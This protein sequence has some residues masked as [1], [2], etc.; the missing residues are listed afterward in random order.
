[1]AREHDCSKL[2]PFGW[3]PKE[4]F[5]AKLSKGAIRTFGI[6]ACRANKARWAWPSQ[7]DIARHLGSDRG[8]VRKWMRELERAR[9]IRTWRYKRDNGG[10]GTNWVL[11]A[12]FPHGVDSP[13]SDRRHEGVSEELTARPQ[14]EVYPLLDGEESP[15]GHG[16]EVTHLTENLNRE[17]EHPPVTAHG[18]AQ[19]ASDAV[20]DH[21]HHSEEVAALA[22]RIARLIGNPIDLE[23]ANQIH[24][25]GG[26]NLDDDDLLREI[27]IF[28]PKPLVEVSE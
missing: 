16:V 10:F 6:L 20:H 28:R 5:E 4:L 2:P 1:M 11:V 21:V 15:H 23:L 18:V 7:H 13:P 26:T 27:N 8:D 3:C 19:N 17:V 14:G 24:Q 22:S 9:L 25:V 12:P